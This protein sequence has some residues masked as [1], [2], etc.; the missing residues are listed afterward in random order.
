[1]IHRVMNVCPPPCNVYVCVALR[2]GHVFWTI[3]QA[4][5][6]C[7]SSYFYNIFY[8][9]MCLG[10][11]VP[12]GPHA[13]IFT[14]RGCKG[15]WWHPLTSHKESSSLPSLFWLL[16]VKGFMAFKIQEKTAEGGLAGSLA[17]RPNLPTRLIGIHHHCESCVCTP[18][19]AAGQM[20][21]L[22]LFIPSLELCHLQKDQCCH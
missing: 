9:K 2:E 10:E 15:Q 3:S 4:V 13:E 22:K 16:G 19:P 18:P 11:G 12:P 17:G 14:G 8:V 5:S 6:E 20:M 1:M 7:F 21:R